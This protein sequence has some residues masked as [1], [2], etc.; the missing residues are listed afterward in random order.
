MLFLS[1]LVLFFCVPGSTDVHA[2]TTASKSKKHRPVHKGKATAKGKKKAPPKPVGPPKP[3]ASGP[4]ANISL[5]KQYIELNNPA[6]ALEQ[7]NLAA[8]KVPQLNDYAQYYR[9]QAE[10]QL[11]NYS[12]VS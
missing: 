1:L 2:A 7:A 4:A 9:A 6:S 8:A 11:K 12:E 3:Q 10:Y 5:A